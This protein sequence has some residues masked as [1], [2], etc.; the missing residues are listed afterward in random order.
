MFVIHNHA[1][2]IFVLTDEHGLVNQQYLLMLMRLVMDNEM[3]YRDA[4]NFGLLMV[5][6]FRR[7]ILTKVH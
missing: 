4:V 2:V 5:D 7:Q 3:L 6:Y 1:V